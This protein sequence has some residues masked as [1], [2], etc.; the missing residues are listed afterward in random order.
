MK[1]IGIKELSEI[2]VVKPSTL[3]QWAE[4]GMIPCYKIN[5]ALRFDMEDILKW[6]ESCKR[7]VHSSY[8]PFAQTARSPRK[9]GRQ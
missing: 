5:G 3:Y 6:V 2:L 4:L 8:N 1:L 9:E 7:N